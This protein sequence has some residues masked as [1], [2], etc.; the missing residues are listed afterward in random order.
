[1]KRLRPGTAARRKRIKR[2]YALYNKTRSLRKTGAVLGLSQEA[3][4]QWLRRGGSEGILKIPA[5]GS[6]RLSELFDKVDKFKLIREAEKAK[7]M[8]GLLL[9]Y[10]L[11][12][13]GFHR[14]LKCFG[15]SY[16]EIKKSASITR[17]FGEY[18]R[19]VR[20]L[21][22]HPNSSELQRTRRGGALYC[23][24]CHWWGNMEGFRKTYG[25]PRPPARRRAGSG[26]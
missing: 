26:K 15:L 10:D 25:I 13:D 8:N 7:N 18:Q 1:M 21:G 11:T 24:L 9:K 5:A 19:F 17:C 4:R 16:R 3:V 14:L 20:A 23:R 12:F 6:L 22:H 2:I